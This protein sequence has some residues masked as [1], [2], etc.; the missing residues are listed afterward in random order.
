MRMSGK[1]SGDVGQA[2]S[3]EEVAQQ[4]LC[5]SCGACSVICP[6]HAVSYTETVGGYLFPAIDADKCTE[7]G[8]C[9]KICPGIHFGGVLNAAWPADS[10]IG[11]ARECLVGKST[12]E[13]VYTA[14]QSGGVV[15]AL[16][17]HALREGMIRGAVVVVTTPGRPPTFEPTVATTEQEILAAQGSKY[18][19]IPLLEVLREVRER[20]LTVALVGLP[21]HVHGL[22]NLFDFQPALEQLV[23]IRIGLICDRV[24]TMA[25]RDYLISRSGLTGELEDLRF[26]DKQEGGWPGNVRVESVDGRRVVLPQ[27]QRMSIKDQFT[28]ARCRLCFDKLNTFSDLT[29]GDPWGIDSADRVN[30]ESVVIV[31]TASGSNL[32][33]SAVEQGAVVLRSIKYDEVIRGQKIDQ[34]RRD[35]TRYCESW[36]AMGLDLPDYCSR[37]TEHGAPRNAKRRHARHLQQ[38]LGL[39]RFPSR[40]DLL[41]HVERRLFLRRWRGRLLYPLRLSKKMLRRSALLVRRVIVNGL[42]NYR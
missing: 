41:K 28:P 32:L 14:S 17:L 13:P 18:L 22:K 39:D 9:L 3:V 24:M 37:V 4:H 20:E 33:K 26:K 2:S 23:P 34:R 19:P 1:R 6:E 11:K 5:T 10:F 36:R 30:G 40:R 12:E 31:R 42:G 21:C 38:A 27:R 16:L 15:T 8:A 7:C 29:V 35:W 25:A